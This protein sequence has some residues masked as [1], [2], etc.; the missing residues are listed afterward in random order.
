M[1]ILFDAIWDEIMDPNGGR[2]ALSHYRATTAGAHALLGACAASGGVWWLGLIVA[3]AYWLWKERG[4]MT[5][6]GSWRDGVEDM[7]CVW[8]GTAYGPW[9]WPFVIVAVMAYI[10]AMDAARRMLC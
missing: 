5:R 3:V 4:D 9:W 7:A 8:L 10:M 6:G 2:L 1:A